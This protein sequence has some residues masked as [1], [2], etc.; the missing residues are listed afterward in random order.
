MQKLVSCQRYSHC[1]LHRYENCVRIMK[2]REEGAAVRNIP[3]FTTKNGVG[4]L[5]LQE[6][7][8]TANAYVR[9]HDSAAPQAFLHECMD[10]CSLAGAKRIYAT[11]H[12]A[13]EDYPVHTVIVQMRCLR[14]SLPETDACVFP[15]TE[16]TLSSWRDIYNRKMTGVPNAAWMT[17]ADAQQML[18][19]GQ[20]YFVHREGQLLGIGMVTDGTLAAVAS[21]C[22][23][24]GSAVV[25]ALAH[26][27]CSDTVLLEVASENQKAM[28]L[29][30]RLGFTAVKE[31]SR[32]HQ[33]L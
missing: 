24:G 21:C 9:L 4:A 2:N 15:V 16:E 7:P 32:W 31:I 23:G 12:P 33:I 6:I 10:F 8:Y 26:A 1:A 11:G 3:V 27:L 5:I 17:D 18:R 14:E 20:G 25:C 19:K 13:L 28:A 29:Y 22:P 30:D